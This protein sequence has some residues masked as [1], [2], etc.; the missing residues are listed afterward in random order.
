M[1][2][3]ASRP[4]EPFQW[5]GIPSDPLA[6]RSDA[7]LLETPPTDP[8]AISTGGA[9]SSITIAVDVPSGDLGAGRGEDEQAEDAVE[10]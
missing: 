1:G 5:A 3:F 4:E 10:D 6:P 2:L 8:F 7:E 9:I